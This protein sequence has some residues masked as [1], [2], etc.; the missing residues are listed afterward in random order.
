M[1]SDAER[2]TT[3]SAEPM[4]LEALGI[5]PYG[6][7]R[8]VCVKRHSPAVDPE[9][10]ER[11]HTWPLGEGGPN[12]AEN[13]LWLCGSMHN[14]VHRLWRLYKR[15]DGAVPM[16]EMR[17]FSSYARRVVNVGWQQMKAASD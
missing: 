16:D 6:P 15:H 17:R 2:M 3:T 7:R 11:H 12:K 1:S 4:G 9:E 14:Q 8:C 13:L 5:D 10:L